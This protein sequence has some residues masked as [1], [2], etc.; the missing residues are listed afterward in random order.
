MGHLVLWLI[1]GILVFAV[2]W[3]YL[4]KVDVVVTARGKVVPEGEVKTIQPL[5]GGVVKKI[6]VREG[7]RVKRNEILL[8]VDSTVMDASAVAAQ[9]ELAQLRNEMQRLKAATGSS[10]SAL[11]AGT[12]QA[13]LS[14]SRQALSQRQQ[15]QEAMMRRL[16]A[17]LA[18]NQA[19]IDTTQ[20]Q[21]AAKQE[22]EKRLA[23]VID[24]IARNDYEKVREEIRQHTGQLESL[25]QEQVNLR[26]QQSQVRHEMGT[27]SKTFETDQLEQLADRERQISSLQAR[28]DEARFRS[29]HQVIRS[30]V[31]GVVDEL[32]L[33]TVGAVVTPAEP[34][35]SIIPSQAPLVISVAVDNKDIG[36]IRTG[37][38][39]NLKVDAFEF[40]RYGALQ[41]RVVRIAPNSHED[42]A[43]HTLMYDVKIKPAEL[44]R[45]VDG[46]PMTLSPGMAV[47]AD[48]TIGQ[49]RILDF[50]L[51][52]LV[53][54]LREG[55]QVR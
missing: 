49:R 24:L 38:N 6:R 18:K 47:S 10:S 32:K 4:G 41:G 46:V 9:Q 3:M 11:G 8:E 52:P 35:M 40:Q 31:D 37:L 13:L 5:E 23:S 20:K 48:I 1:L 34:V 55:T 12:Q 25:R 39:A 36:F 30:P 45:Q 16:D 50:F 54:H 29:R 19:E 17:D 14:A 43:T 28:I 53:K 27:V 15:S 42:T 2:V 22:Q 7:Q 26:H 51:N 33:H 44:G 21:L